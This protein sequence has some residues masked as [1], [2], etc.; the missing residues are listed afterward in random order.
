MNNWVIVW[1][2]NENEEPVFTGYGQMEHKQIESLIE[3]VEKYSPYDYA[4]VD[5]YTKQD[6]DFLKDKWSANWKEAEK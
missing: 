5:T 2:K 1:E 4:T 3:C 6:Y